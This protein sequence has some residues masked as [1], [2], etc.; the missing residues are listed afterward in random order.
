MAKVKEKN[1]LPE[2]AKELRE[3][4]QAEIKA[5][6]FNPG[7]LEFA[8]AAAHEYGTNIGVTQKMRGWFLAQGYP[9]TT[10][11]THIRIPERSF[12][13][14][15]FD[16]ETDEI[17]KQMRRAVGM[18]IDGNWDS[19]NT[20]R[21]IGAYVVSRIRNRIESQFVMRSGDLRD[22]VQYKVE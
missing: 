21:T 19:R 4:S 11:T 8:I 2:I 10:A 7:S 22:S 14:S 12:I 17:E 3:V 5:G 9:L 13:R 20:A 16:S 6:V 1:R 15:T 18:M